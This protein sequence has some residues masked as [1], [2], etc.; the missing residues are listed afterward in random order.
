M[1]D[2][3]H[4][5]IHDAF[6]FRDITTRQSLPSLPKKEK[7]P[8]IQKKRSLDSLMPPIQ[9]L[10]KRTVISISNSLNNSVSSS[11]EKIMNEIAEEDEIEPLNAS[12]GNFRKKKKPLAPRTSF[13]FRNF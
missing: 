10:K 13:P 4:H 11:F 8:G 1:I 7:I 6:Q 2:T 12:Q 5:Q 3:R 9:S